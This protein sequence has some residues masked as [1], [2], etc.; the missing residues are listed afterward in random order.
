MS[1]IS[2]KLLH[3]KFIL[4]YTWN[5]VSNLLIST[6]T[7]SLLSPPLLIYR[8]SSLSLYY[9]LSLSEMCLGHALGGLL[10]KVR[11]LGKKHPSAW[12]A[13]RAA[14]K[15]WCPES[16][17]IESI[18]PTPTDFLSIHWL[19]MLSG[20]NPLIWNWMHRMNFTVIRW[21]LF[22]WRINHMISSIDRCQQWYV[23]LEKKIGAD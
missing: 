15:L 14:N 12:D 11:K 21:I 5:L 22:E 19:I 13:W 9:N 7:V 23:S 18:R 3:L 6:W 1:I 8:S 10:R 16:V 17:V 20:R 2:I 4:S